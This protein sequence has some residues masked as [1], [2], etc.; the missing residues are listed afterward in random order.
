MKVVKAEGVEGEIDPK[1]AMVKS[2][3][4]RCIARGI[5]SGKTKPLEE[6]INKVD[7]KL[8]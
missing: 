1:G 8:V 5:K 7:M 4:E 6:D 2:I 3:A